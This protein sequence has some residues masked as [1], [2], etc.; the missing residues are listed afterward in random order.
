MTYRDVGL[1]PMATDR[2]VTAIKTWGARK[3]S[4]VAILREIL[5]QCLALLCFAIVYICLLIVKP[6][7]EIRF[8]FLDAGPL[9]HL[10]LNLDLFLRRRQ[11]AE[12]PSDSCYIFFIYNAA[13]RQLLK[14]FGRRFHVIEIKWLGRLLSLFAILDTKFCQHLGMDSNEY[15]E[16]QTTS[17]ELTFTAEEEEL[18][19]REL[20]KLGIEK[21]DWFVCIFARDPEHYAQTYRLPKSTMGY[22]DADIDTYID[23]AKFIVEQGGYIIRMGMNVEKPFA[24]KHSRVIDYALNFRSDFMDVYLTAKCKCYIGTASGG[25]DMARI[26]DKHHLAVNWTPIGWAP[27][28]KNEIYMPK[29]LYYKATGEQV[30]YGKALALTAKWRVS[31]SFDIEDELEKLGMELVPN[32]P[33]QILEATK[34]LLARVDQT[35]IEPDAYRNMLLQYFGLRHEHR[36]WCRDVYTPLAS[37]YLAALRF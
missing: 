29:T 9:G 18:G 12:A 33:Q 27:W 13:N 10:A 6:Y 28:G 1:Q 22:R 36:N 15:R 4:P 8:G 25:A 21:D 3:H 31:L 2:L 35:Y 16:Y 11:L 37:N 14:M 5:F 7:R 26:F 30:P 32:T 34:E 23:A 19:R 17:C 20:R 24:M